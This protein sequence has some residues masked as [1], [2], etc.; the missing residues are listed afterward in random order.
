MNLLLANNA[1]IQT[2][3]LGF[4]SGQ[5]MIILLLLFGFV[6]IILLI[7]YIFVSLQRKKEQTTLLAQ[8]L[9]EL[10]ILNSKK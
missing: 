8:I 7:V 6:P 10:R 2:S 4:F 9:A 1:F 5:D 3:I